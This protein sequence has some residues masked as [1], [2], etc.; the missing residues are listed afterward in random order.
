MHRRLH[1][2]A[3]IRA[4]WED[5]D[6]QLAEVECT[7]A[8]CAQAYP[9]TSMM[10]TPIVTIAAALLVSGKAANLKEGLSLAKKSIESGKA[11][12]V[13]GRVINYEHHI[14]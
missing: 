7:L 14:G 2:G 5:R 11:K 1:S 3:G 6:D 10:K 8:T 12:E 13:L 4:P 9:D